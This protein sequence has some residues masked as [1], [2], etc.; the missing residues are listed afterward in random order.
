MA[1]WYYS[2]NGQ[3]HGPVSSKQL[4]D[5]AA[6]GELQP[7]NLVW[8]EGMKQWVAAGSVKGLFV[9]PEVPPLFELSTAVAAN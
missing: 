9:T 4:K 8:K 7:T 1:Q 5:L 6:S 3:Q 2:K